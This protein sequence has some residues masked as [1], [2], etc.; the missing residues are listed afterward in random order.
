MIRFANIFFND[1]STMN[2]DHKNKT[3]YP[4]CRLLVIV[5]CSLLIVD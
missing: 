2:N 3:F 1:Q 5:H 4:A